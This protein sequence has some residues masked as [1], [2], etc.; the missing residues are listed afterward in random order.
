MVIRMLAG[1]P[2]R[3]VSVSF[4]RVLSVMATVSKEGYPLRKEWD[5][6][7]LQ[8]L[9]DTLGVPCTMDSLAYIHRQLGNRH[10][11]IAACRW[12]DVGR[13]SAVFNVERASSTPV[14]IGGLCFVSLRQPAGIRRDRF[15]D[16][17]SLMRS[18][19]WAFSCRTKDLSSRPWRDCSASVPTRSSS[20]RN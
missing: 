13:R 17:A 18:P 20:F 14:S 8:E 1:R 4:Q 7:Q 11:A 16:S 9:D 15:P 12:P 5:S 10:Q 6:R 19:A 3:F 2:C